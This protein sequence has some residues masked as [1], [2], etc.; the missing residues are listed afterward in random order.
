MTL[1]LA[2]ASPRR[3]ELLARVVDDFLI[4]PSRCDEPSD[5][6]PRERVVRAASAKVRDVAERRAGVIVGADTLVIVGEEVLGKPRSRDEA[7]RMLEGLSGRE[8]RVVT[9]VCVLSTW[10]GVEIQAVEETAVRFRDLELEE[11]ERYVDTGEADDK[12][13]AYA[14]QGRAAAFVDRIRGDFHN[15]MGLPLC[16]LVL[17]LREVGVRV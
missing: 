8:H 15:V 16:R 4:V 13:G 5:G 3:R 6:P 9:G 1:V 12:A 7:R 2:S 11:I 17:M 14:I 10:T